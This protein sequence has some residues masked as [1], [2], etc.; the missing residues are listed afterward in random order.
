MPRRHRA[1]PSQLDALDWDGPTQL[2]A[3]PRDFP[4]QIGS[5]PPEGTGS[6]ITLEQRAARFLNDAVESDFPERLASEE[7]DREPG[8][9]A[10]SDAPDAWEPRDLDRVLASAP[11]LA[12]LIDDVWRASSRTR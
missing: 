5:Q 2:T 8:D 7:H 12:R 9:A 1:P 4:D 6:S 3:A 11:S 10:T